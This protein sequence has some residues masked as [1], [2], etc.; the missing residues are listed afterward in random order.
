MA[1]LAVLHLPARFVLF[2]SHCK[3]LFRVQRV[4][5]RVSCRD[6]T[7]D[8]PLDHISRGLERYKDLKTHFKRHLKAIY[9]RFTDVA[10]HSAVYGRH[11]V[12]FMEGN[13]IYRM[14]KRKSESEP[15]QVLDLGCIPAGEETQE[16]TVQRIRLSPQEKHLAATVKTH[17]TETIRCV[18][19]KLGQR[20]I[21]TLD[22][23]FTFEWA[24]DEV[25]FYTIQE[26]LKCQTVYRLDLTQNGST[27]RLV[28]EESEPDV[29]VEVSLSRD[30]HAL[31]ITCSSRNSSEVLLV[32]VSD[33]RLE[34]TLVQA[35]QPELLYHVEHWRRNLIILANTGPGQEY[36]V[37]KAPLSEPSMLSWDTVF[38][39]CLGTVIKDMDVVRDHCI[40]V[41]VTTSNELE[42]I[43][44][45]LSR[46]REAYTLQLP[47]WACVVETKRP[48]LADQRSALEFL[49]SSPV[50]PRVSYCLYPEK[51]L[52]SSGTGNRPSPKKQ[53]NYITAR[54][55]ACSQDGTIVPVTLF[56]GV[57]CMKDTPLL[58]HVYGAYGR[59]VNMQ[60]SP[61]KRFL[62]DQGWALAYCHIRGGGERGLAWQRQARVE[63]KHRGVE[64]LQACLSHLFSSGVYSPSRTVLTAC[65]AGGVPVGALCNRRPNMMRAVMLQSPFLDVLGTMEDPEL[66]LTLEDR[67][68]WG[69]PAGNLE[70]RLTIASYCP[71]CNI[72]PQC[73]PSMLLTAYTDD[74]R[75]PLAGVL[76]YAEK[77]KEAVQIHFNMAATSD[78]EPNIVVNIQPGANHIGSDDWESM[79]EEEALQLA[80]L[81]K[82][83]DLEPPCP[84]WRRKR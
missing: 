67:E 20:N 46:P 13:S 58:V 69:D 77:L 70:H 4:T 61:K 76:K 51:G 35:R 33:P 11:H 74:N 45:P 73:Y 79:L 50:R 36:Q 43:V 62:L 27:I 8:T 75:T 71:V 21:L 26:N 3:D 38:T 24:T 23:V 25:L 39:P 18:V 66:H 7:N 19:V 16:W 5:K 15:E 57:K 40:L 49:I 17:N 80:F 72:T 60:F 64:D 81:Y 31:S 32:D 9:S 84:P 12:Y 10:D 68:E 2:R 42:L 22:N 63:G 47:S 28:Y 29:F 41:A 44:V 34:P 48:G 37:I 65:S 78:P 52:L 30:C 83:M 59:D 82:E 1:V 56:H 6:Y 55:K 14:E 53:E 54:L